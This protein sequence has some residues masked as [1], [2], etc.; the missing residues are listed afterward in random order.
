MISYPL[1]G[2]EKLKLIATLKIGDANK[3][4]NLFEACTKHMQSQNIFQWDERYPT[5]DIVI[6]DI[7]RQSSFGWF[8]EGRLDGVI[9]LNEAQ[10]QEYQGLDWTDV[11]GRILV[12]HRLAVSPERQRCGVGR[13][14]MDFAEDFARDHGYSSIRLDA[15]T[16]NPRALRLYESRG[17]RNIGQVRFPRRNMPFN[18][19]EKIL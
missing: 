18:C 4:L 8:E 17:Y 19:Y 14:L 6:E 12:I 10:D 7:R 13:R 3:A 16:G 9:T 11:S 1:Y 2:E 5:Y 15:Y